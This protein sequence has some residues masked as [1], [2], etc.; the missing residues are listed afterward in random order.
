MATCNCPPPSHRAS[1]APPPTSK[2]S[3]HQ[4]AQL[5][6]P[7]LTTSLRAPKSHRLSSMASGQPQRKDEWHQSTTGPELGP[8]SHT[9]PVEAMVTFNPGKRSVPFASR[10]Q[11]P[12]G[13]TG[14]AL[15]AGDSGVGSRYDASTKPSAADTPHIPG[16][17]GFA[18]I[19]NRFDEAE[20]LRG[21]L[22]SQTP[23]RSAPP[24]QHP[25]A[26]E[27]TTIVIDAGHA[28]RLKA[29]RESVME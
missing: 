9:V 27:G 25:P 6:Q 3:A 7:K 14:A 20:H 22:L 13:A 16:P 15:S 29:A 11:R 19:T 18:S 28:E 2:H 5:T 21:V 8:G 24:V 12:G 1:R 26:W 23:A 17:S 10:A 4:L